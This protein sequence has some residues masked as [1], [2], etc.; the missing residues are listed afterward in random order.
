MTKLIALAALIAASMPA[1]VALAE[2]VPEGATFEVA[3]EAAEPLLT[4]G[5]AKLADAPL[6]PPPK[7]KNVK[8]RVLA[9]CPHG[10][11]D[12]VI[13]LPAEVAKAAAELGQVDPHKDA[14]AYALT[15][16]QNQAA[17]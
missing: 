1:G 16:P 7:V 13:T 17:A 6:A 11:P 3:P 15:L 14:V 10:Q 12:D 9:A 2:D 5:L 8:V 4:Q